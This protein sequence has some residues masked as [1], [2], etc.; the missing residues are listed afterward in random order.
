[1]E[2]KNS[3]FL[4]DNEI[5]ELLELSPKTAV[6][7]DRY[8]KERLVSADDLKTGD[9][10]V[11]RE[12]EVV[13]ADGVV[14]EGNGYADESVITG[15]A[16]SIEKHLGSGVLAASVITSGYIKCRANKV[17]DDTTLARIIK[18]AQYAASTK[19]PVELKAEKLYT[20]LILLIIFVAVLIFSVSIKRKILAKRPVFRPN[21]RKRY[22][23]LV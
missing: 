5:R 13:P 7:V 4:A 10:F 16:T 21:H 12:G 1:M 20:A 6:I 22:F 15:D 19:A 9:I 14:I 8:D 3:R 2:K 23:R 17:G 11:V 18:M